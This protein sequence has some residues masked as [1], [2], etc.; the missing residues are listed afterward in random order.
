MDDFLEYVYQ[1]GRFSIYI[2]EYSWFPCKYLKESQGQVL[3][4]WVEQYARM[5]V[6]R[7]DRSNIVGVLKQDSVFTLITLSRLLENK[8]T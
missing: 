4:S 6:E 2:G 7:S 3:N 8:H 5:I 1:N